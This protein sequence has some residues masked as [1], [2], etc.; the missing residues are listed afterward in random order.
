MGEQIL[1]QWN[2]TKLG[3]IRV[4]GRWQT[5]IGETTAERAG[6]AGMTL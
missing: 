4:Q 3:D 6:F 1:E 2:F 5:L